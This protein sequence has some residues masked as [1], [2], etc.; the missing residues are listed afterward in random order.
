MTPQL[1]QHVSEVVEAGSRLR[2][3]LRGKAE[4]LLG[5]EKIV[6]GVAT[7]SEPDE[8]AETRGPTFV[9]Q[10]VG[11]GDRVPPVRSFQADDRLQ[12]GLLGDR[13]RKTSWRQRQK[14]PRPL[15]AHVRSK[16]AKEYTTRGVSPERRMICSLDQ[17]YPITTA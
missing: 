13:G 15:G 9:A 3:L 2:V 1:E 4:C 6:H 10:L 11:C 12:P 7:V 16:R 14:S 17:S 8:H 5:A